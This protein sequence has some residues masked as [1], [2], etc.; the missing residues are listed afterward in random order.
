MFELSNISI[1]NREGVD[2]RLIEISDRAIQISLIDF[3]HPEH[4]GLRSD[5]EQNQLY[6]DGASNCDG[7][8]KI[9]KHQKGL[10]LDF[11]AYVNGRASWEPDHLAMVAIAFF[12]AANELGYKIKWGGMWKRKTPKFVNGIPYGWDMPHVEIMG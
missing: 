6:L 3:G 4:A 12:Q 9:S 8:D 2:P 7:Y 10:A 1:Q 11:Y 5:T